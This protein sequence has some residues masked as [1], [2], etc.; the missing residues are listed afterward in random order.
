M[1][2]T[3]TKISISRLPN[4]GLLAVTSTDNLKFLQ[5]QLT[6]DLKEVTAEQ[7]RYGALCTNK[8]RMISNF[9]L[10]Q[11]APNQHLLRMHSSTIEAVVATLKKFAPFYKGTV[12]D[13]SAD[14]VIVG[15]AASDEAVLDDFVQKNFSTLPSTANA[16]KT[17]E[18]FTLLK[19]DT[20]RYECWI[21]KELA[22]AYW[23]KL[24]STAV[25]INETQWEL[26]NIRAGLGEVRKATIEEW[27][28]HML[29]LQTIGAINFKKG[30][31]TGQEIVARTEYRGLQKRAMYRIAGSG[32]APATAAL[33]M[34]G[35]LSIG[36]IVLSQ[37]TGNDQWEA[38]AVLADK[39]IATST[40]TCNG[41]T[42]TVLD[43]PYPI[44]KTI[45]ATP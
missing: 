30:C 38:L 14:Y 10:A 44:R 42:V 41:A 13:C 3:A 4:S 18:Q 8:G 2:N 36:E 43:L 37:T 24:N 25:V 29:N 15:I 21:K 32:A 27:T 6:C 34:D 26:L 12:T 31:Y 16:A 17:T 35:E 45:S 7:W 5:G 11:I 20:L 23:Q 19:L 9:L 33:L 22:D 28:P 40:F 39:D 1:T